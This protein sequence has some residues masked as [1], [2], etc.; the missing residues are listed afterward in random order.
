M[1]QW[2]FKL[3]GGRPMIRIDCAFIDVVSGQEVNHYKDRLG[4]FWLAE[5]EW[6]LFRVEAKQ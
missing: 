3:T 1:R 2:F 6:S 4:R 5:S